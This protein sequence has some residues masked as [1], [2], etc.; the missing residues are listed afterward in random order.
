MPA[1][2]LRKTS[3]EPSPAPA[4]RPRRRLRLITEQPQLGKD[5]HLRLQ[6]SPP[7]APTPKDLTLWL[8]VPG[9]TIPLPL[10][11]VTRSQQGE[12]QWH[13]LTTRLPRR[14]PAGPVTVGAGRAQCRLP[15]LRPAP[16]LQLQRQLGEVEACKVLLGGTAPAHTA[17]QLYGLPVQAWRELTSE[18][19]RRAFPVTAEQVAAYA[20]ATGW[21]ERHIH[22]T[23]ADR[24]L[25]LMVEMDGGFSLLRQGATAR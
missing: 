21:S 6:I 11:A 5:L 13:D 15:A 8:Q 3:P 19:L 17:A 10:C 18:D 16:P 7:S 23:P 14:V 12:E 22:R 9:H 4:P 20:C 25:P 2:S 24:P 1:Q